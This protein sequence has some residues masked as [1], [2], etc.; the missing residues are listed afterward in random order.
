ML[1]EVITD[2]EVA[3]LALQAGAHIVNDISGGRHDPKI[4]EVSAAHQAPFIL[5]HMQG[6]P[7][8][9]HVMTSYSIHYTKLYEYSACIVHLPHTG[10]AKF[11]RASKP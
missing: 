11:D 5:M 10:P 8:T 3:R 9:M 2:S 4:M 7:G 6:T 1:Y